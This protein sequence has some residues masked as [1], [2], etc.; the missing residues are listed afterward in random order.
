MFTGFSGGFFLAKLAAEEKKRIRQR[1]RRTLKTGNRSVMARIL[2]CLDVLKS[3]TGLCN[4]ATGGFPG[5]WRFSVR[6]KTGLWVSFWRGRRPQPICFFESPKIFPPLQ[7][8]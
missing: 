6:R 8:N 2:S 3:I 4:V 1:E 5:R 7:T